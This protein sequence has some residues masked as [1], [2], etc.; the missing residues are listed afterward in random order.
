[1]GGLS[2]TNARTRKQGSVEIYA[3]IYTYA[4][5]LSTHC[6]VILSVISLLYTRPPSHHPSNLTLVNPTPA[7]HVFPQLTPFQ[8]Y[9]TPTHTFSSRIQTSILPNLFLFQLFYVLIYF[10]FIIYFYTYKQRSNIYAKKCCFVE[11]INIRWVMETGNVRI[12]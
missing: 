2:Q 9:G 10:V 12:Y 11:I 4:S 5:W 7:C 6:F 8:P 1:M 3:P